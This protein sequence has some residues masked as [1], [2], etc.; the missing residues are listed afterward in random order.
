MPLAPLIPLRIN[1]KCSD[2]CRVI[3]IGICWNQKTLFG[4]VQ[5]W[6][7]MVFMGLCSVIRAGVDQQLAQVVV[8]LEGLLLALEQLDLWVLG[9]GPHYWDRYKGC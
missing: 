7:V 4:L 2:F 5:S 8:V 9:S 6:V 3:P 1:N